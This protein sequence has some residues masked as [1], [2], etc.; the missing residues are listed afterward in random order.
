MQKCRNVRENDCKDV[1]REFTSLVLGRNVFMNKSHWSLRSTF[2]PCACLAFLY[3]CCALCDSIWFVAVKQRSKLCVWWFSGTSGHSF[4]GEEIKA[5][6]GVPVWENADELHRY[7]W[8]ADSSCAWRIP[9]TR[10]M[11]R[12]LCEA[13]R[14]PVAKQ[15]GN[16]QPPTPPERAGHWTLRQ[17]AIFAHLKYT[18]LANWGWGGLRDRGRTPWCSCGLEKEQIRKFCSWRK[19]GALMAGGCLAA[20]ALLCL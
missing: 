16:T 15:A 17:V 20:A 5:G 3:L 6:N 8:F 14:T 19:V 13:T 1:L 4:V 11:D 18:H 2:H 10:P 9:L 12:L 7:V